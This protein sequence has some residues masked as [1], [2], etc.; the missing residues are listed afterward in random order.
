MNIEEVK[1]A[2]RK[3]VQGITAIHPMLNLPRIIL[4]KEAR[5]TS[6]TSIIETLGISASVNH[7]SQVGY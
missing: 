1:T 2:A 7:T 3:H 5:N 4:C 6:L